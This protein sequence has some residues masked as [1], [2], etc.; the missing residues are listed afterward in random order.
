MNKKFFGLSSAVVLLLAGCA[1]D[2]A[3]VQAEQAV[4]AKS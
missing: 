3:D 4:E 2:T 1:A